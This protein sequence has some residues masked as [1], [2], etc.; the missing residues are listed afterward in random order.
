MQLSG[1]GKIL[2]AKIQ[3]YVP[4]EIEYASAR[5]LEKVTP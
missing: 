1:I 3:K 2:L 5:E 4:K